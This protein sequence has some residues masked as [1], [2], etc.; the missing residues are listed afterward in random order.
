[1]VTKLKVSLKSVGVATGVANAK[2]ADCQSFTAS[3]VYQNSST[4]LA[5]EYVLG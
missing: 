2:L 5:A 3:A 4:I 1:M